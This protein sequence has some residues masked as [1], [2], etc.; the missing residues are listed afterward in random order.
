[1]HHAEVALE[2][3]IID[4]LALPKVWD[5]IMDMGGNFDVEEFR[6]GKRKDEKSYVRLSVEAPD[7]ALLAEIL[8][9][10]QQFGATPIDQGEAALEAVTQEGVF[11]QSFYSTS[12]QPTWVR[13]GE[14]WLEVEHIEMDCGI[15][16][17]DGRAF[18][19]PV[20]EATVGQQIV[21]G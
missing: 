16:V 15:A 19:L 20:D 10:I 21:T 11:P 1:M 6:V 13:S 9:A 8:T 2:G 7:E 17:Q 3:H 5:T 4:S 18:C 12:N 14:R